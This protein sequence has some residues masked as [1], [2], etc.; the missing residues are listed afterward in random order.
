MQTTTQATMYALLD[1]KQPN[2]SVREFCKAN[3]IKE[4]SYYYW[5]KKRKEP[6]PQPEQSFIAIEVSGSA[7]T[8]LASVQLP[9]GALISI[10]HPEAFT[11]VS[12]LL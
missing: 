8:L 9:G 4:A 2:Q 12:A 7:N 3:G 5:L 6:T 10:Y 1:Q 11:Y